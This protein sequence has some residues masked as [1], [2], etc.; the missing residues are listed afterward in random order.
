MTAHPRLVLGLLAFGLVTGI[1]AIWVSDSRGLFGSAAH[2][3]MGTGWPQQPIE[4]RPEAAK[5]P[6]NGPQ[7]T[8]RPHPD[9]G[10]GPQAGP[11]DTQAAP[12]PA[13]VP[14]PRTHGAAHGQHEAA[15]TGSMDSHRAV[16]AAATP[17]L[18]VPKPIDAAA[19]Q[20]QPPQGEAVPS[21]Y[22]R[23]PP[24]P[25]PVPVLRLDDAQPAPP[26]HPTWF[27]GALD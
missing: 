12:R 19:H 21:S 4:A 26:R 6:D 11:T 16:D 27:T 15:S 24:A 1:A 9:Q 3:P 5:A 22:D 14:S 10:A 18:L 25:N 2:R 7:A 13:V 23:A 8:T 20:I 17:A